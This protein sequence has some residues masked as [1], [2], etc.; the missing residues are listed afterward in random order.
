MI[1]NKEQVLVALADGEL[2]MRGPAAEV[3]LCC[4]ELVDRGG[5]ARL[6]IYDDASGRIADIDFSGSPAVILARLPSGQDAT[7]NSASADDPD[8]PAKPPSPVRRGPGRPRL[9]VVCREVSLLPRHWSWLSEQRGGASAAL[10]RLVDRAR[11]EHAREDHAQLAIEAAH[12][13]LWDLAGDLPGFEEATRALFARDFS[14]LAQ[15]STAWP[16]GVRDQLARFVARA[17]G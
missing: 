4:K 12:R 14:K 13:F 10:R 9:G 11:K 15:Y 8:H 1:P 17:E 5:P 3:A 16:A 2:V 7:V 6:A